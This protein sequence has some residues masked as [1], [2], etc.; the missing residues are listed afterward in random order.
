MEEIEIISKD[1]VVDKVNLIT[2]LMS[3]DGGK[4]Y[5]V[6]SK[7]ENY[8]GTNDKIIYIS[9]LQSSDNGLCISEISDDE[10]WKDVQKLLRKVANIS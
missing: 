9:I 2:Y 7:N 1:G 10:E 3:D 8:D 5:I 4:Q 6:Y